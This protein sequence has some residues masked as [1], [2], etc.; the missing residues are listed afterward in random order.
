MQ[1]KIKSIEITDVPDLSPRSYL[2]DN[3]A[4]FSCTV[5]LTIGPSDADGGELYYLT[6][7]SP[8]WLARAC[9]KDGFLWGRHHLI[10]P[11]YN[12]NAITQVITRFVER[13][14][15]ES[16]KEVA[17]KLNRLASWEFEDYQERR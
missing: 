5:G 2:P 7:C 8:K 1:A 6:V 4:D 11:E 10:V 9:E 16:W 12:I 15:G 17:A 3:L 14:V 13:C